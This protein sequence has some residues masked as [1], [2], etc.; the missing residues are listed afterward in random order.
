MV[1]SL[2][3]GRGWSSQRI[4]GYTIDSVYIYFKKSFMT[5]R[6]LLKKFQITPLF[7]IEPKREEASIQIFFKKKKMSCWVHYR[8]QN[9]ILNICKAFKNKYEYC[10]SLSDR[11]YQTLSHM[12]AKITSGYVPFDL[13][14]TDISVLWHLWRHGSVSYIDHLPPMMLRHS[15]DEPIRTTLHYY[16][17]QGL[18]QW[19]INCK[20]GRWIQ[21]RILDASK[22]LNFDLPLYYWLYQAISNHD[23]SGAIYLYAE[24]WL[25]DPVEYSTYSTE[26]LNYSCGQ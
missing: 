21:E 25:H 20:Y 12:A 15:A 3:T 7:E 4:P 6:H 11:L 23:A 2:N 22:R 26:N 5:P 8:K 14:L 9:R 16:T 13:V 18:Q 24:K 19:R 17:L 1:P 10:P